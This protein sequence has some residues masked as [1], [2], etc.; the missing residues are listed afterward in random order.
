[1]YAWKL[2]SWART[3]GAFDDI[4]WDLTSRVV[5]M[6]ER[7]CDDDYALGLLGGVFVPAGRDGVFGPLE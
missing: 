3:A 7:L 5:S 1:M 6:Y 4:D 2:K